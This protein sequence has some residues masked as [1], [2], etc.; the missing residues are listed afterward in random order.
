MDIHRSRFVPYPPATITSLAFSHVGSPNSSLGNDVRLAVGRS[1]GDIEL[2]NPLQGDWVQENVFRGGRARTVEGLAWIQEPDESVAGKVIQ[3]RL[4]LFSVG[5]SSAI[6]EWDLLSGLPLRDASGGTSPIWCMAAQPRLRKAISER[7]ESGGEE[8]Q[9]HHSN[10]QDLV[11]GCADGSLTLFSTADNDVQFKRY[12]TRAP[13]KKA[14]ALCITFQDRNRIVAGYASSFMRVYDIRNGNLIR[15]I[16]L[17]AGLPGGPR[18]ILV[19]QVKCLPSGDIVSGNSN[20]EIQIWDGRTYSQRQRIAGHKS[21]I[22]ALTTSPDGTTIFSGGTDMRTVVYRQDSQKRWA[23]V[24]N[25]KIHQHEVK[26]LAAFQDRK[27]D[28]VVSG[29]IDASPVVTPIRQFGNEYWRALPRLPQQ[30]PAIVSAPSQRLFATW[31][32]REVLIWRLGSTEHHETLAKKNWKLMSRLVMKSEENI[33][34]ASLS[35]NGKLLAVSTTASIKLFNLHTRSSGKSSLH[36]R[37]IVVPNELSKGA[38]LVQFSPDSK[39]MAFVSNAS[40]VKM[41][42]IT[43]AEDGPDPT[44][45]ILSNITALFRP[46]KSQHTQDGLNGT[47]GSYN[48]T[49]LRLA[50]SSDSNVLVAN[51]LG[52][53]F[54]SWVLEGNDIASIAPIDT[55]IPNGVSHS[56]RSSESPSNNDDSS[57][58]GDADA[59]VIMGQ[60]WARNRNNHLLPKLDSA[61]LILSFRPSHH[62]QHMLAN[63]NSTASPANDGSRARPSHKNIGEYRLLAVTAKHQIYE[64][65]ILDGK[66]TEWSRRNP[67]SCFPVRWRGIRDR[68]M[69]CVWDVAPT[70]QR[71]RIWIYGDR[72][73]F[74]FDMSRDLPPPEE[75]SEVSASGPPTLSAEHEYRGKKRKRYDKDILENKKQT[76]GA[77]GKV[78][79]RDRGS[80]GFGGNVKTVVGTGKDTSDDIQTEV[81]EN[82]SDASEDDRGAD[83][84]DDL[85][86]LTRP[87]DTGHDDQTGENG[88]LVKTDQDQ[89]QDTRGPRWWI[90][91]EYRSILGIAPVS[92]AHGERPLEVVLVER[93]F[94]DLDLPP[95]FAG[96]HDKN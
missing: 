90:T 28:V 64:F 34:S 25:E 80:L 22:L 5:Y 32:N 27:L 1:N 11:A 6:T 24:H 41:C 51:D 88:I 35:G 96:P 58:D 14:Q 84:E 40:D 46:A 12:I 31:W 23:K 68:A 94:W 16:T 65:D 61:P 72:W 74:M 75:A 60:H 91:F 39:W 8:E 9:D 52:G 89:I 56:T 54:D 15:N 20:G 37:K 73:L 53:S 85:V 4:R 81:A 86:E 59:T 42:R 71:E 18:E 26:A 82:A 13:S 48:N 10:G 62:A 49:I 29:G 33:T 93:P 66:L 30:P 21:D 63:G 77:G 36:V 3:G 67:T 17:G 19:W 69:G 38:R 76:N 78:L 43:S 7:T 87:R 47:W 55:K 83:E 45:K 92:E 2:W 95:R 79:D 44:I 50:F 70:L 57:D